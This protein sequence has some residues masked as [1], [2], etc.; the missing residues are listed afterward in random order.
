MLAR[1]VLVD[2]TGVGTQRL[3][4][5][6]A[7]LPLEPGHELER[8]GPLDRLERIPAPRERTVVGDEDGRH[9]VGRQPLG[10]E[11][12]DDHAAGVQ[13]VVPLDFRRAH[14]TRDG[15]VAVEEVRMR[16]SHAADRQARLRERRRVLGVRMHDAAD[17]RKREVERQVGRRV[18]RGTQRAANHP[19]ALERDGDHVLRRQFLV[20]HAARLDHHDPGAAVDRRD[21]AERYQDQAALRQRRLARNTA[22]RSR[23]DRFLLERQQALHERAQIRTGAGNARRRR[24][25][26]GQA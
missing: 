21:D 17:R 7:D 9:L 24:G 12:L 25:C 23:N 13:F 18:G 14:R 16:R 15:D 11:G 22:S 26:G 5:E 20:G 3:G 10:H 8:L 2:E 6:R 19:A 4:V 1:V